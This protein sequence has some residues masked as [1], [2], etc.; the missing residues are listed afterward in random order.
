MRAGGWARGHYSWEREKRQI[1]GGTLLIILGILITIIGLGIGESIIA[2]IG[3]VIAV[4]GI[5]I[6]AFRNIF[7]RNR[8]PGPL[9]EPHPVQFR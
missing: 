1:G 9:I 7:G 4:I 6:F 2:I 8:A 5:G 3:F